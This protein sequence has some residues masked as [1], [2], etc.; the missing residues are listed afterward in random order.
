MSTASTYSAAESTPSCASAAAMPVHRATTP[1][2]AASQLQPASARMPRCLYQ[3]RTH[4]TSRPSISVIFRPSSP[5]TA[6]YRSPS[7]SAPVHP[8]L[9]PFGVPSSSVSIPTWN[10]STLAI[11]DTTVKTSW[12]ASNEST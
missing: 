3:P 10:P 5:V 12:S 4:G 2:R 7:H 11:T 8:V 9:L 6:T 1:S